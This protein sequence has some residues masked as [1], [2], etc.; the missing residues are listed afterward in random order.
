MYLCFKKIYTIVV[1]MFQSEPKWWTEPQTVGTDLTICKAAASSFFRTKSY[2][3]KTHFIMN[4]SFSFSCNLTVSRE[5]SWAKTVYLGL[6]PHKRLV[7]CHH[8]SRN[9]SSIRSSTE[10]R[11]RTHDKSSA[12]KREDVTVLSFSLRTIF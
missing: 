3:N 9:N 10:S 6:S 12:T 2:K 4:L 7:F 11:G 5:L 1:E 8:S